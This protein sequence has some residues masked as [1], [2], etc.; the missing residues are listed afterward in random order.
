MDQ[1]SIDGINTWFVVQGG[2][3][4]RASRLPSPA[5]A[6]TSCSAAI[7]P[8]ATSRAGSGCSRLRRACRCSARLARMAAQPL[9]GALGASPKSAGMLELGGSYAGA[10]L[11]RR[12]LFMPWELGQ[13]LAPD[14]VAEGLRRLAPLRL[15]ADAL[16]PRP[17]SP[18]AKVAAL[19]ASLYMRNQLLRDTD[20]A[21][22][23]HGLEVR[24]PLVDA[25]LLRKVAAAAAAAGGRGRAVPKASL[26]L[27]PSTP[28]PERIVSQGEDGLH[29]A[30]RPLAAEPQPAERLPQSRHK[31]AVRRRALVQAVGGAAGRR[32][33]APPGPRH[34]RLRGVRRHRP[35][36]PG[37]DGGTVAIGRASRRSPCCRVSRSAA[38][39]HARPRCASLRRAPAASAWS[40]RALALAARQRFDAVFCGHLNAVPLAAAIAGLRRVAALGAGARHRGL[41]AARRALP[42]RPAA[43]GAHHLRQ[44]VHARAAAGLGRRGAPPGA[45][46]AQYGGSRYAPRAKPRRPRRPARPRRAPRRPHGRAAVRRRSATRATTGSS[47]PCPPSLARVPDAAYLIVGSGDDQPRLE[48]LAREAGVGDR[49]VFAGQVADAEL[50]DYFAL[51]DVFAMPSTGEGFGIVFLEAA[52]SGLPVIGGNRDGSVDALADGRIGRLVDPRRGGDRGRRDR[53]AGGPPSRTCRPPRSRASPSTGSRPMSTPSSAV[54]RAEE[55]RQGLPGK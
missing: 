55:D 39:R 7:P 17:R 40:A 23:A 53:R 21:S 38:S 52:A 28:L 20:W 18:H 27:S 1:P 36:Q 12:G 45:R 34:R 35:L 15:I 44:P 19:E 5:S 25:V 11:L 42:P 22:M 33:D 24:T 14:V 51:A 47:P 46:A 54:S 31:V 50:A 9:V 29:D 37:P 8:S 26:A 43:G 13:V 48:R 41:A 10:Y 3:R 16:E 30:D 32:V 6:A 4:A 2:A 49:V